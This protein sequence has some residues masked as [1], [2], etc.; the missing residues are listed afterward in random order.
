MPLAHWGWPF[1]LALV[2]AL[3]LYGGGGVAY[4][5]QVK[6]AAVGVGALPHTEQWLSLG[7]LVADGVAFAS[8]KTKEAFANY[9]GGDFGGGDFGGGYDALAD[10]T[11]PPAAGAAAEAGAGA[12]DGDD[13]DEKAAVE[14]GPTAAAAEVPKDLFAGL[15]GGGQGGEEEDDDDIIE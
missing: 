7:G 1:V 2:V 6:G 10:A 4:N 12:T 3:A 11:A 13:G 9:Q 5:V 8:L 14:S 15:A